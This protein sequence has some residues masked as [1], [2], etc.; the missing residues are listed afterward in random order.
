MHH[1]PAPSLQGC[2]GAEQLG[3][4]CS[5]PGSPHPHSALCSTI[6]SESS[7]YAAKPTPA[8]L[9]RGPWGPSPPPASPKATRG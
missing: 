1:V 9:G 4:D 3:S 5:G 7:G 6:G 2:A 8:F